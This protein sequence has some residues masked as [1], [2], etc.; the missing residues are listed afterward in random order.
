M[1]LLVVAL[2]GCALVAPGA[3]QDHVRI[4][5][6]VL[7][8]SGNN[9]SLALDGPVSAAQ[10]LIVGQYLVPTAG[11]RPTVNVDL[12]RVPQSDYAFMRPG[13]RV[14]VIG[15]ASSDRRRL[16]ATSIIRDAEPQAP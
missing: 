8:L 15:A 11:P 3:A 2:V 4:D 14:S 13:E 9:L 5:G 7:W 6:T 1:P 10:Y 16:I 12:T